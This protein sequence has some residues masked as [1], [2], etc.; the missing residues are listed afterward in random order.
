MLFEFHR[1]Q[2]LKS[3]NSVF[4]TYLVYGEKVGDAQD[5]EDVEMG[6]NASPTEW[7]SFSDPC[8]RSALVLVEEGHLKGTCPGN[9]L[10]TGHDY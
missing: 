8:Q 1:L 3:P 4:A 9:I 2:N 10:D 5:L 6:S 7:E